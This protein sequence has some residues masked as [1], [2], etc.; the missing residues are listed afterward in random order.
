MIRKNKLLLKFDLGPTLGWCETAYAKGPNAICFLDIPNKQGN[1]WGWTNEITESGSW[2]FPIYAG[3]GQCD[4]S[5]GTLV[6]TLDVSYDGTDVTVFYNI[7]SEYSLD[8]IHLWVGTDLLPTN[9]KDK[10]ISSPGQFPYNGQNDVTVTI[11]AP[12]YIAAHSVVCG[13]YSE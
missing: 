1:N 12:F 5:K 7:D 6:G 10:Y 13:D 3:A 9:K 4:E 11:A 2:N 8:E